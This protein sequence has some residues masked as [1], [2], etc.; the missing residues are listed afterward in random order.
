MSLIVHLTDLHL[1]PRG[2]A[3]PTDDRKVMVVGDD[4]R[5]TRR[6]DAEAAIKKLMAAIK[7]NGKSI[8]ALVISG[9]ITVAGSPS[10]FADLKDFLNDSF[11]D[12]LPKASR[13]V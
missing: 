13:I 10:G 4:E 6:D 8:S 7:A 11:G 9:D 2:A 1:G 5:M 3:T 12:L